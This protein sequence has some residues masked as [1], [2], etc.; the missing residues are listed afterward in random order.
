MRGGT[1]KARRPR[2]GASGQGIEKGFHDGT[3]V[4]FEGGTA[5]MNGR[6]SGWPTYFFNVLFRSYVCPQHRE[7]FSLVELLV[8]VAIIS[9]LASLLLP[10]LSRVKEY[11]YFAVC[12]SNLKQMGYGLLIYAQDN[13]GRFPEG[14]NGCT[15]HP[16]THSNET[17]TRKMGR[18]TRYEGPSGGGLIVRVGREGIL[19]QVY[20]DE[21]YRWNGDGTPYGLDW[22]HTYDDSANG[23]AS[24][25]GLP[26]QKGKYLPVEMLWCP[27]PPLRRWG[28]WYDGVKYCDTEE[29]RDYLTRQGGFFGYTLFLSSVGCDAD[30]KDHR[31]MT[32]WTPTNASDGVVDATTEPWRLMTRFGQPHSS[33]SAPS[34]WLASDMPPDDPGGRMTPGHFG[35]QGPWPGFRF[36]VL[37][38]DGHVDDELGKEPYLTTAWYLY[39]Y[40][41]TGRPYG[42]RTNGATG[43]SREVVTVIEGA[44]DMNKNQW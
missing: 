2:G 36:N 1:L 26:R 6:N 15:E 20:M 31:M 4:V 41:L 39:E 14:Y 32:K 38:V 35:A 11:A 10:G 13:N 33:S 16:S 23:Y 3:R 40:G 28:W 34:A 19:A 8:V 9:I 5:E 42:W 18:T 17:W 29:R 43:T 22:T 21:P 25:M 30:V 37:H 7:G 44:F 24:Y 12:K 27:I